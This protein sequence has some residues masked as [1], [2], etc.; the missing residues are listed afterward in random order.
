MNRLMACN[1]AKLIGQ[2]RFHHGGVRGIALEVGRR[3]VALQ[4]VRVWEGFAELNLF[5]HS[6]A[7]VINRYVP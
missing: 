1:A 4:A 3:A 7:T 2:Q 5:R 6:D